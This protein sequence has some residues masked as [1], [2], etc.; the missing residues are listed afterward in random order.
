L[1]AVHFGIL[2]EFIS[3]TFTP[4]VSGFKKSSGKESLTV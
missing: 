3:N 4:E 2:K 1:F